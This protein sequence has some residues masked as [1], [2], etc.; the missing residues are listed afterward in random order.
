MSARGEGA[1]ASGRSAEAS[2]DAIPMSTFLLLGVLALVWGSVFP[3]IKVVL[4]E[5]PVLTFRA[6]CLIAGGLGVAAL[7]TMRG[8]SLAVTWPQL[9][10]LAVLSLFN[11]LGWNIFTAYGLL[12]LPAGRAIIIGYTMPLWSVIAAA[13][14][15]GERIT[16]T[17]VIGLVLGFAGLAVL[18][19]PDLVT[20]GDAP[21]GVGLVLCAAISWGIGVVLLKWRDMGMATTVLAAWQLGLA[22]LPLI[23][24]AAFVDDFDW[25]MSGE[26]WFALAL[27]VFGGMVTAHLLW[28]TIVKRLP[29]SIAS[30]ST[31]VIPVIGVIVGSLWLG[32][33]VGAAEIGALALV[34]AG[35]FVVLVLPSLRG[36]RL[37]RPKP[38]PNQSLP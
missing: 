6:L 30:I 34:V 32:E 8:R 13:L 14:I 7:A 17:K 4:A 28:F 29:A 21:I 31:L 36:K 2:S 33:T 26:G 5:M 27:V 25:R 10:W 11:S 16:A 22:S 1:D 18:V 3:A 35:L 24:A 23:V 38:G 12:Y 15:L 9:R 19:G 20:F 37:R